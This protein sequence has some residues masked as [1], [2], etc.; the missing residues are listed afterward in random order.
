MPNR[1]SGGGGGG[2]DSTATSAMMLNY[3]ES[4]LSAPNLLAVSPIHSSPVMKIHIPAIYS[5]LPATIQWILMRCCPKNWTPR[6]KR[7]YLI[8]VGEYI[9]RFKDENDVSPK[10]S[11]I[12]V[13]MADVRIVSNENVVDDDLPFALEILPVGYQAVFEISSIGKTQYFAVEN[14]E[15]ASLWVN[16]LRQMRQDAISR[17]MGHTHGNPYPTKWK[18]LDT[19]AKRL[20]DKKTRIKSKLEEMNRKEQE[21]QSLGGGGTVGANMGYY[22]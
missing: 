21:M 5:F 11:P 18:A 19:S 4:L 20:K 13:I 12:P 9:Y 10:G 14:R 2:V 22:S 6:W 17:S 1:D 3:D 16:T 8:A 15:E 7:R